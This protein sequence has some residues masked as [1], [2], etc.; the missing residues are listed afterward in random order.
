MPIPPLLKLSAE[1]LGAVSCSRGAVMSLDPTGWLSGD[2]ADSGTAYGHPG[3][4]G[5]GRSLV[6][7]I[8]TGHQDALY[9]SVLYSATWLVLAIPGLVQLAGR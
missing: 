5:D 7:E 8:R 2:T 9:S 6:W 1:L 4:E 3:H